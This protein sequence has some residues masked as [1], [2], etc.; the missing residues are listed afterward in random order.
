MRTKK[1]MRCMALVLLGLMLLLAVGCAKSAGDMSPAGRGNTAAEAVPQAPAAEPAYDRDFGFDDAAGN[2]EYET[3]AAEED[4]GEAGAQD[5][6]NKI[7]KTAYMNVET[8]TFDETIQKMQNLL[9]G[10]GGYVESSSVSGQSLYED[11]YIRRYAH[12]EFRV[13]ESSYE[14]FI[15]SVGELGNVI[16]SSQGGQDISFQYMDTEARLES[17]QVQE[18]R[19]ISILEKAEKIEDVIALEQELSRVRYE[20]ESREGQLRHWDN[21]VSFSRVSVDVNE[22]KEYTEITEEPDTLWQRIG[23]TLQ[24]SFKSL[25]RFLENLLVVLTAVL[26]YLLMLGTIALIVVLIVRAATRRKRAQRKEI[27]EKEKG[28]E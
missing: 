14:T 17:L 27:E 25:V 15:H 1:T 4:A 9:A 26:P 20:I 23:D 11:R 8:Y 28:N 13:P 16:D 19:L 5:Y 22:V 6:G 10:M 18:D 3:S 24:R 21:L 2:A 12:F 7:I